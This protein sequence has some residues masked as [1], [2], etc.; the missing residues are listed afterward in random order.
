VAPA[1]DAEETGAL[2]ASPQ[3]YRQLA[4]QVGNMGDA[5]LFVG[6]V[7]LATNGRSVRGQSPADIVALLDANQVSQPGFPR[8][9]RVPL[10]TFPM[11]RAVF[12]PTA[13]LYSCPLACREQTH[14]ERL[15]QIARKS[16]PV[17]ASSGEL[18]DED[19]TPGGSRAGS[20]TTSRNGRC[21]LAALGCP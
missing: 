12:P 6:D 8:A 1:S 9:C 18:P 13:S 5:G 2:T 14:T 11:D 20:K 19:R 4:A 21:A 15:L 17:E 16:E 3:C 7:L 10:P